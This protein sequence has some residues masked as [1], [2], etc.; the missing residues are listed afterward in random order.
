MG[1]S[2]PEIV[3]QLVLRWFGLH[4]A[5]VAKPVA[6]FEEYWLNYL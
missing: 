5:R 3:S 4:V 1:I 6:L 2:A